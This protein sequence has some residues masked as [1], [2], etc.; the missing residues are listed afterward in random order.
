MNFI[1]NIKGFSFFDRV[2][3]ETQADVNSE[4]AT[5]VKKIQDEVGG[6]E[7]EPIIDSILDDIDYEILDRKDDPEVKKVVDIFSDPDKIGYFQKY[8]D[9]KKRKINNI[10]KLL[11]KTTRNVYT[12]DDK[13]REEGNN[14]FIKYANSLNLELDRTNKLIQIYEMTPKN[15]END[16]SRKVEDLANSKSVVKKAVEVYRKASKLLINALDKKAESK[17]SNEI[18]IDQVEDTLDKSGISIININISGNEVPV[19]EK[20]KEIKKKEEAKQPIETRDQRDFIKKT[21]SRLRDSNIPDYTDG[22]ITRKG[23]FFENVQQIQ[24]S[25]EQ[26]LLDML[27]RNAIDL[28]QNLEHLKRENPDVKYQIAYL[29]VTRVF[30]DHMIENYISTKRDRDKLKRVVDSIYLEKA[31][32]IK[33]KN[34]SRKIN[35]SDFAGLKIKREIKI[36]L[37]STVNIPISDEDIIANS[38]F[39]KFKNILSGL[40]GLM[41]PQKSYVDQAIAQGAKNQNRAI[42][43]LINNVSKTVAGTLGG[44]KAKAKTG[45]AMKKA[46]SALN[47]EI[48]ESIFEDMIAPMDSGGSQPGLLFDTP[49]SVPGGMDTFAKLGPGGTGKKLPKKKRSKASKRKSSSIVSFNDFINKRK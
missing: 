46:G 9:L 15:Q 12:D 24:S 34:L 43:Q 33:N 23:G 25:Y 7:D 16:T 11:M 8:R 27:Q 49:Q 39:S 4:L 13:K 47:L 32:Y 1:N 28:G 19:G 30:L 48:K 20:I 5:I 17:I 26:L 36:P 18:I 41:G 21:I 6:T 42:L 38:K 29:D 31:A 14:S 2:L 3:E 44:E 10:S 35:M 45:L 22:K 40:A 37:Y